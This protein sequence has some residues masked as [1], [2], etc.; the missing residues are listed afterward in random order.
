VTQA[1]G[2]CDAYLRR[3]ADVNAIK[4]SPPTEETAIDAIKTSSKP[5]QK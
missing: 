1:L 3:Q 5:H 2:R 4:A